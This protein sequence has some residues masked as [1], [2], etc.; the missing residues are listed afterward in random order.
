MRVVTED[1]NRH[2]WTTLLQ[3]V[4]AKGNI[5]C[6]RGEV[7]RTITFSQIWKEESKNKHLFW[8]FSSNLF[9]LEESNLLVFLGSLLL[10][11]EAGEHSF[12]ALVAAS[13]QS[14]KPNLVHTLLPIPPTTRP[15]SPWS[16]RT[17]GRHQSTSILSLLLWPLR[18]WACCQIWPRHRT[19]QV[20]EM[21]RW[22]P[23]TSSIKSM[24]LKIH[25]FLEF[26][27]R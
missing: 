18:F 13:S 11:L 26:L 5:Y 17:C 9:K 27:N 3:Y 12:W 1:S 23:S 2:V 10:T 19:Q 21:N 8:M 7:G 20:L 22:L 4:S 16:V 14:L 25:P 24:T 15:L 6:F